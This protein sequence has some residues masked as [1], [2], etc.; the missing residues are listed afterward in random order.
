MK[1]TAQANNHQH[2]HCCYHA[3]H[4][5]L[6]AKKDYVERERERVLVGWLVL[7]HVWHPSPSPRGWKKLWIMTDHLFG[8]VAPMVPPVWPADQ[9]AITLA[10]LVFFSVRPLWSHFPPVDA[11]E[12]GGVWV[13]SSNNDSALG[14][15][16]WKLAGREWFVRICPHGDKHISGSS[17]LDCVV[18]RWL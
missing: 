11:A 18:E 17:W 5:L 8:C 15:I 13:S 4:G 9:P 2:R 14:A 6:M 1:L 12:L 16:D 7:T 3:L 10:C